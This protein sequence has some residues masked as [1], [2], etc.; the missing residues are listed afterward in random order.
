MKEIF[1]V[2][3]NLLGM[4]FNVSFDICKN[5]GIAIII[6]TML[7]K[8][9]LF[10]INILIQKNSI[11]MVKMKP[12]I[13]ELKIKHD[14]DKDAF[15]EAQIELF[16]KE[17]YH[18]TVGVI[19]LLLQIPIILGLI[20]VIGNPHMYID[21]LNNLTFCGIN[22][23]SIPKFYDD[24]II[25]ILAGITT[26]LLCLFQ[27]KE[28]VLQREESLASKL[29]SGA[30]TVAITIYFV[31]YVPNGVGLYWTLGNVLG[32][33]QLYL[34]NFIF[35]PKKYVDYEYL[36]RMK[37]ER[38]EKE[39]KEKLSKKKSKFY[40]KK[41]F[42]EENIEKMRLM[43]YSEQSGFFKYYK[44]MIE[45][46][47]ENSK[48][49]EIHYVTSDMNDKIFEYNNPRVIPYYVDTNKLIPLFM[50][51]E[52][53][54]VVMTTPEL[55]NLY[56][57]RSIIKKDIEYIFTDHGL[58]SLNLLYKQNAL[59]YYDTVFAKNEKQELE[60]R[61]IEKIRGTKKKNIIQTG[62][63]LI[64]DMIS[65]Y[66]KNKKANK[67]KTIVI[68]PSWQEDNI[69]D[70]CLDTII[71]KMLDTDY[72]IV[73]R[74]HPQYIRRNSAKM[75]ALEEKY[76][77]KFS[78]KFILEKDFS[79]NETVYNAD[80]IIT[81]WSG[82]GYEF[83]FTTTK[84]CLFINTKMKILNPDYEK[85][86]VVPMDIEVRDKLGRCIEKSEVE[87]IKEYIDDLIINQS[88]YMQQNN[89]LRN[90]YI[91][92]LGHAA[93]IEGKYIIKRLEE[94]KR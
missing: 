37:N 87:N 39:E 36:N 4:I 8:I 57:K 16:E 21:N 63:T 10:P 31:F 69:M 1:D 61:E 83:V 41:F 88:K 89:M 27:N 34:L 13:D 80:L 33:V 6:F 74:P 67:Y 85:V 17:K 72:K 48:D 18:P 23:S 25:P 2:F 45:Y 32:I 42:K 28:N 3:V 11:K 81:D 15:M 38:K 65:D 73:I 50:K 12:K 24:M 68:A 78:D 43:F 22:L 64:E 92:N 7:S 84:P 20:E 9:I 14:K 71:E 90:T 35:P 30:L 82:I 79:S 70:S 77:D 93:E 51:L 54:I 62:Y 76:N 29:L 47:L 53:D 56:L 46:I 49:I 55:Q 91:S 5:Y 59:D 60:I 52:C 94:I 44:G 75:K 66:E 26:I 86:P 40:Y 19:P 58:G